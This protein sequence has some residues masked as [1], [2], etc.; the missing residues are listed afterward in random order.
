MISILDNG[1]HTDWHDVAGDAFRNVEIIDLE[2]NAGF[3]GGV[4]RA[5]E[6]ARKRAIKWVWLLNNDT[7][8]P[9]QDTIARM[10]MF[11]NGS[12]AILI[13]PVLL[14][15]RRGGLF[16]CSG[17]VFIPSLALTLH[18]TGSFAKIMRRFF[19]SYEYLSGTAWFA[20]VDRLPQPLLDDNFFAYF[21]DVD[22]GMRLG[23]R[24]LAVCDGASVVHE[25]SASTS[26]SLN[27][28]YYKA[29]NVRYL[30]RKHNLLN[31]SFR[32]AYWVVFVMTEARKYLSD[33]PGY[34]RETRR[35]CR[36]ADAMVISSTSL[37]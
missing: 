12:D 18:N 13:T 28:H 15:R 29:R 36:D 19:R 32:L 14:N 33:I 23:K 17:G 5:V 31:W 22:L 26:G 35:A 16:P 30:A 10:V 27:K 8:F 37:I 2:E 3:T 7:R 24:A 21:E 25:V 34:L 20:D 4:N 1:T 6:D 11:A 9:E